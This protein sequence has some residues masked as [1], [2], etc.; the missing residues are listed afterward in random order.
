V[1][2]LQG[3]G[4]RRGLGRGGLEFGGGR[5]DVVRII[6]RSGED[7]GETPRPRNRRPGPDARVPRMLRNP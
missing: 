6:V 2:A 1:L 7:G 5:V 4:S 3:D